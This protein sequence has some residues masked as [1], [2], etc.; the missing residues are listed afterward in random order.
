[1]DDAAKA[2]LVVILIVVILAAIAGSGGRSRGGKQNRPS[3][4]QQQPPPVAQ[5]IAPAPTTEEQLKHVEEAENTA[6]TLG[7]AM[8]VLD[9]VCREAVETQRALL[10]ANLAK[11]P[12]ADAP[13][14]NA[15]P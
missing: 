12:E 13:K 5:E 15:K 6:A 7:Q 3:S 11:E 9:D 8:D 14:E 10:K 2:I 1:M 4:V